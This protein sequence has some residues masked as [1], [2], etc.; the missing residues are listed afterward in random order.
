M[1]VIAGLPPHSFIA[2][3]SFLRAPFGSRELPEDPLA[4][5]AFILCVRLPLRPPSGGGGAGGRRERRRRGMLCARS[6][7]S[8]PKASALLS[9][10]MRGGAP[11]LA[12]RHPPTPGVALSARLRMH[13]RVRR[14]RTW[15][16]RVA[17]GPPMK[18]RQRQ[19]AR[20]HR[21]CPLFA[22]R[23]APCRALI[24]PSPPRGGVAGHGEELQ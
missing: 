1:R 3:D 12:T 16:G 10:C 17:G 4:Q 14:G 18:S 21:A 23:P 13:E 20:V 19:T 11:A 2:A 9:S 15:D 6:S 22:T 5:G 24:L 7:P 8:R